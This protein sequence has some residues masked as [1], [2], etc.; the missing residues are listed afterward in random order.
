[1]AGVVNFVMNDHFQ[2]ARIDANAGGWQHSQHNS[3]GNLAT[4]AGDGSAPSSVFD[5]SNKQVTVILGNNFAEGKGNATAYISYN[6]LG[7]VLQSARDFS[8]CTL[9]TDSKGV[10]SCSGSST[11]AT[12]R[13]FASN[14]LPAPNNS[15]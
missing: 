15:R 5:G 13:F 14:F 7:S 6:R 10:V 12:G 4:Q 2:G 1:V 3:V 8:L 9:G 11:S